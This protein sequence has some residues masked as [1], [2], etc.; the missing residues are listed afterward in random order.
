MENLL[1]FN[2]FNDSSVNSIT[3]AVEAKTDEAHLLLKLLEIRDQAHIFH[4]QTKS[5]A[6][7]KALGKFYDQYL[8]KIDDVAEQVFGKMGRFYLQPSGSIT[9]VDYS[10]ETMR[11]Y[12]READRFFRVDMEAIIPVN[13]NE[14]IYNSVEEVLSL[15]DRLKYRLT[16]K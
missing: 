2:E 1:H 7:H 8:D 15:V 11:N 5:Y 4:W 6:E 16:L 13:G 9:L 10:D 12:L 3:E 14:E